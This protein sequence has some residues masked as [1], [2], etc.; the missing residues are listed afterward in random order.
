MLR[1][2]TNKEAP[3]YAPTCE[4]SSTRQLSRANL[5]LCPNCLKE[6]L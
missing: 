4:G 1:F 5:L 3:L 6:K 2:I